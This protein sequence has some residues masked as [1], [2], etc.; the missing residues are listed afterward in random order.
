VAEQPGRLIVIKKTSV[1]G[2]SYPRCAPPWR[3]KEGK[4]SDETNASNDRDDS[5]RQWRQLP[6]RV[7]AEDMTPM[8]STEPIPEE[9]E[10]PTATWGGVAAWY[11]SRAS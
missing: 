3:Y 1:G 7:Q 9:L 8:V 2:S 10:S 4:M 11:T 5:R 6:P